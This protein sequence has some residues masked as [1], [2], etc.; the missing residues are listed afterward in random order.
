MAKKEEKSNLIGK[1]F[2]ELRQGVKFSGD[3]SEDGELRG[4][5]VGISRLDEARRKE[6][7]L[8]EAV[9]KIIDIQTEE[10]R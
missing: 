6:L 10:L 2:S 3:W 4:F 9:E 7:E 1:D 5:V 8:H